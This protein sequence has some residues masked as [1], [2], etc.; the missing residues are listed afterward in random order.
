MEMMPKLFS[1]KNCEFS[2]KKIKKQECVMFLFANEN[3][4]FVNI[5]VIDKQ[6]LMDKICYR[7]RKINQIF[8]S[9]H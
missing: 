5:I 2:T 1:Y 6:K 3:N 9:L 4:E 8:R 7:K